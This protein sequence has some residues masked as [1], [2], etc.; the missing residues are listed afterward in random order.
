MAAQPTSPV[1]QEQTGGHGRP[2]SVINIDILREVLSPHQKI[3]ISRLAQALGVSRPTVYANMKEYGIPRLF[4]DITDDQLDSLVTQYKELHPS[5]GLRFMMGH[6]RSASFRVQKTRV[7][8]SLKRVN[9]VGTR[10][11]KQKAVK[12]REYS[13]PGPNHLWHIDGHH[14]LIRWGIVIHSMIDGFDRMVH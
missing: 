2:K 3:H 6:L 1:E 9:G 7:G 5:A 11:R 8:D 12:P 13:V 10:L 14:K 4:S